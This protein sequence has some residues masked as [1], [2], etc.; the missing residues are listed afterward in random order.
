MVT[1][2]TDLDVALINI[3]NGA[4]SH[5]RIEAVLDRL[6]APLRSAPGL[7]VVTEATGWREHG[8]RRALE[9]ADHLS[10]RFGR[11]YQIR[12]GHLDRSDHPIALIWD[13]ALLRLLEW[14]DP[15]TTA[16]VMTFNMAVFRSVFGDLTVL[17]QHWHPASR[18]IRAQE[19]EA[20]RKVFANQGGGPFLGIGDF[21]T[22]P[23]ADADVWPDKDWLATPPDQR[24][25]KGW[26]PEG[27]LG[28]WAAHTAPLD[29]LLG[30]W[31]PD[32]LSPLADAPVP[33]D[34][35]GGVGLYAIAEVDWH[36]RGRPRKLLTPTTFT[37]PDRG[38]P[39]LIDLIVADEQMAD[40]LVPDS[41]EVHR[42]RPENRVSDHA[43]VT[44]RFR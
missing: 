21:N 1:H 19:A 31:D 17:P 16:S 18:D 33:G 12:I 4:R 27:P 25:D 40:A 6:L 13:P 34:R 32:A 28:P 2:S 7:M 30:A 42:P 3:Q 29:T 20:L 36:Q 8:M 43:L 37:P 9:V 14:R 10:E 15:S 22:Y 44:A 24:G 39:T 38:G 11:F 41:Y 5:P 26:Q 23:S 35:V